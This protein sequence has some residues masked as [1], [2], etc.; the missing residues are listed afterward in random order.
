MSDLLQDISSHIIDT[1][2]DVS[3]WGNVLEKLAEFT[4]TS[5]GMFVLRDANTAKLIVQEKHQVNSFFYGI[6]ED[7]IRSY[8]GDYSKDDIWTGLVQQSSLSRPY[9]MSEFIS[10]SELEKS[11]LWHWLEPQGIND[12]LIVE[13]GKTDDYQAILSL[14]FDNRTFSQ[15]EE[16]IEAVTQILPIMKKSF[17][18]SERL[19]SAVQDVNLSQT[20]FGH[21][22]VPAAVLS[23]EGQGCS[24]LNI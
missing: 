7:Q 9:L 18:L 1:I 11:R 20:S 2:E 21:I 3:L 17:A 19:A 15:R 5:K 16:L 24:T 22:K 4:G 10:N 6:P 14:Y 23:P 13:I 8:V 12:C